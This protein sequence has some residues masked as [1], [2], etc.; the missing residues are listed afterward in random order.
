MRT[1]SQRIA[2]G[3]DDKRG[4]VRPEVRRVMLEDY[5]NRLVVRP[6]ADDPIAAARGKWKDLTLS[7]E[8]LRAAARAEEM[9]ASRRRIEPAGRPVDEPR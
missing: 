1:P 5:G 7:T 8:E 2:G 6:L 4:I 9:L 3:P